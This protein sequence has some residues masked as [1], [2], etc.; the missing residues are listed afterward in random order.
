MDAKKRTE[1]ATMKKAMHGLSRKVMLRVIPAVAA[2]L[3][4]VVSVLS[5][6]VARTVA[7][8]SSHALQNESAKDALEIENQLASIMGSF[9]A[10]ID[11]V[12]NSEFKNKEAAA[13]ALKP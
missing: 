11:G 6:N 1:K 8:L 5:V 3:V 2:A 13:A 10:T 4:I 12:A 9:N 7:G